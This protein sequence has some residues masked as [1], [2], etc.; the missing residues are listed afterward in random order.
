MALNLGD[1]EEPGNSPTGTVHE[2]ELSDLS[3]RSCKRKKA[4]CDRSLPRCLLC[5]KTSHACIYPSTRL[6]PGPKLGSRNR[7]RRR[8][9]E[10]AVHINLGTPV[11]PCQGTPTEQF[12][13][14]PAVV[15]SQSFDPPAKA[16]RHQNGFLLSRSTGQDENIRPGSSHI[17]DTRFVRAISLSALV[18]PSHEANVTPLSRGP[19]PTNGDFFVRLAE[20]QNVLMQ[21]CESLGLSVES[22]Q[23]LCVM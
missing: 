12:I 7:K 2:V 13:N 9:S 16:W 22:L 23:L 3:C 1:R 5:E 20:T 8:T 4:K 6:K 10:D 19:S 18:H 15:E 14:P 17:S 11:V 21:V